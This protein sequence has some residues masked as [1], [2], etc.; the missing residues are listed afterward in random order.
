M[1]Q[2]SHQGGHFGLGHTARPVRVALIVLPV[3]VAGTAARLDNVS[4][5]SSD[6]TARVGL[7]RIDSSIR[8]DESQNGSLL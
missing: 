3:R 6:D 4:V 7:C 2:V 8:R 5:G 1:G